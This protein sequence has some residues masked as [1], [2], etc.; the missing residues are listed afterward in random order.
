MT[1]YTGITTNLE[2]RLAKHAKGKGAKYTRGREPFHCIF[3]EVHPTK[4][5][6]LKRELEIKKLTKHEK[7]T[8]TTHGKPH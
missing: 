8:L 2:E 1:L 6:A 7:L 5:A 3:T 4:S